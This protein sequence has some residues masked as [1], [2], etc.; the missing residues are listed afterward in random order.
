MG[1]C[2]AGHHSADLSQLPLTSRLLCSPP[3]YFPR[4]PIALLA[5]GFL[6]RK[7]PFVLLQYWCVSSHFLSFTAR[8]RVSV[9]LVIATFSPRFNLFC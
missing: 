9:F 6:E 8:V 2:G 3:V 1:V 5:T 7:H 4:K